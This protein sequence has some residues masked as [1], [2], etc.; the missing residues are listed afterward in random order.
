MYNIGR[1][2]GIMGENQE[3]SL[4]ADLL[5]AGLIF[6]GLGWG[7]DLVG[8]LVGAITNSWNFG[9]PGRIEAYV[10]YLGEYIMLLGFCLGVLAGM[11]ALIAWARRWLNE[12]VSG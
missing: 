7:I 1:K 10:L 3:S 12:V 4:Y 9:G 11:C 6:L 8:T 2:E 5:W